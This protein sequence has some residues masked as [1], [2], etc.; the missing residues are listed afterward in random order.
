VLRLWAASFEFY[1]DSRTNETTLVRLSEAYRKLRNTFRYILGNLHEFDPQADAVPAAEMLEIDQW[2]LTRAEQLVARCRGFYNDYAFHR[3]YQALY[4]FAIVD[5]SAIY[6]D[7]LKD[8]LYTSARRSHARRSAQTALWRLGHALA[9]LMAPLLTFTTDEVW[10]YLQKQPGD[11]ESVH[12][13]CFPQPADL[14]AGL[15]EENRRR[16][17][18]WERLMAIRETV[19]KSLEFARQSKLIGG[20]LEAA[21]HLKAGSDLLPLLTEY[22]AELPSLFI[23]S[24]VSLEGHSQADLSV[25]VERAGGV[26]CERC[27]KY[28]FDVGSNPELSSVCAACAF[29]IQE[30]LQ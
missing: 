18:K 11:P 9:R 17:E 5:L 15:T 2:I 19:S 27:W 26:K 4:N 23:V 29:A 10:S 30:T 1:E 7:I 24:Q 20:S 14:T 13:T 28:T 6:F 25:H 8:R 22:A 16:A 3:V 21:L 12:L